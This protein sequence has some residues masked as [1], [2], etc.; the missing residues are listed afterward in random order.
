[1]KMGVSTSEASSPVVIC[2]VDE[3]GQAFSSYLLN[4]ANL[5]CGSY[6]ISL[7][8]VCVDNEGHHWMLPQLNNCRTLRIMSTSD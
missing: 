2:D 1:M 6:C 7:Q 3:K 5:Q 4:T 8:A